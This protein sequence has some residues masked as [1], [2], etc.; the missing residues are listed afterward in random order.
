MESSTKFGWLQARIELSCVSERVPARVEVV[1]FEGL[2]ITNENVA[3]KFG[4]LD[5][6][7]NNR[8]PAA[9]L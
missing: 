6:G 9:W 7:K 2:K 4:I 3:R 8:A 5:A 1:K